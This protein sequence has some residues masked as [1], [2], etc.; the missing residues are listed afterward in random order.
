MDQPGFTLRGATARDLPA[1]VGLIHGLAEY[2]KLTHQLEVTEDTLGKSLF[3]ERPVA[4]AIVAEDRAA[5]LIGFAL[6]FSSFSTFLGRPGLWLEDLFV[7]PAHRRRG[8]GTALLTALAHIAV[9]RDYGRFEWSV[10]DWN[11]SALAFYQ[12]MGA[13][14]L[15]DWRICRVTGDALRVL[16]AQT[17]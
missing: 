11:E 14:V 12:R 1:L 4:E 10:L 3:G 6:F 5:E 13:S 8:V 15:S 16:G 9:E 7:L 2:E 17:R